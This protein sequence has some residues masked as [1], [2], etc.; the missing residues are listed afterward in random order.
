MTQLIKWGLVIVLVLTI[1]YAV[2]GSLRFANGTPGGKA[3][4]KRLGGNAAAMAWVA[5]DPVLARPIGSPFAA[6]VAKMPYSELRLLGLRVRHLNQQFAAEEEANRKMNALIVSTFEEYLRDLK[7]AKPAP[8]K[9]SLSTKQV[10]ELLQYGI[11]GGALSLGVYG[12]AK[13]RTSEMRATRIINRGKKGKGTVRDVDN[14]KSILESKRDA[15]TK[16]SESAN[17]AYNN[18]YGARVAEWDESTWLGRY[19]ILNRL[20]KASARN[21]ALEERL[22]DISSD[23][24]SLADVRGTVEGA[25]YRDISWSTRAARAASIADDAVD[26][27]I[28]SIKSRMGNITSK[29]EQAADRD[30]DAQQSTERAKRPPTT[31]DERASGAIGETM[32]E[33]AMEAHPVI[34]E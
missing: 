6:V 32:A 8:T 34:P 11:A 33:E 18:A 16:Q 12:T 20:E 31:S 28:S 14:M 4:K 19:R 15:L 3:L 21:E 30:I 10:D 29:R 24:T 25:R 13:W 22:E 1:I 27:I 9:E 5:S 2:A 23:I 26:R 17:E 7:S